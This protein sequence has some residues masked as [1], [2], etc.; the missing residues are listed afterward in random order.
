MSK[1]KSFGILWNFEAFKGGFFVNIF[2]IFRFGCMVGDDLS[3]NF[4]QF[5][6]GLY[7][8]SLTMQFGV[9]T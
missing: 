7:K 2:T 8:L 5:N 9:D 4:I 1:N 6:F 3:G